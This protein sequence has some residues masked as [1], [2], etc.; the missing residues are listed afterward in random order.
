M[1]IKCS[2]NRGELEFSERE[3]LI[4]STG[5]EYFRVT[6]RSQHM[7]ADTKVYSFDPFNYRLTKFF[8]E[9]AENWKG[10]DGEKVWTSLEE[11]FKIVCTSDSLGHFALKVI[12]SNN[13]GMCSI[14]TIYIESG[15][16]DNIAEEVR[17]FFNVSN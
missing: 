17:K 4:Q 2:Q 16:L 7:W 1:I 11:E 6:I 12:I 3:G 8:E 14:N 10:F 15:Q 5:S 9:L 13:L